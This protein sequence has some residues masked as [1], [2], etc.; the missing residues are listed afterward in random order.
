M[1][2]KYKY[3]SDYEEYDTRTVHVIFVRPAQFAVTRTRGVMQII[4][5]TFRDEVLGTSK[6]MEEEEEEL[7]F[8]SWVTLCFVH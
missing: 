1:W 6:R 4:L 2:M 5:R 7:M 3:D 8:P